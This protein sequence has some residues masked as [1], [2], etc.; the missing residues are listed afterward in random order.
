[1][2]DYQATAACGVLLASSISQSGAE[3]ESRSFE[4][5][6]VP[7]NDPAAWEAA[8]GTSQSSSG[9]SVT[10]DRAL[11]YSPVWQAV[12]LISGDV[13]KLPLNVYR[14]LAAEGREIDRAHPAQRVIRRRANN[15]MHAFRFWRRLMTHALIWNN[16]YAE[17]VRDQQ[18]RPVELLPLLP[19]RTYPVITPSGAV[20]YQNEIA[21]DIRILNSYHVLHIEGIS[22]EGTGDCELVSKARESWGRGLAAVKLESKYY[23]NGGRKG[24]ILELPS[25]MPKKARDRLE[26]D[27]RKNY[28]DPDRAFRT[29]VLRENA[30]FHAAQ[31]D[32]GELEAGAASK[33]HVRDVARWY[34]LPPHK[35]GDDSRVAHNSLEQ[36]N[37]SYLDG[38]LDHWLRTIQ[39]EA[40]IKMLTP[41]Q[42]D[43]HFIEHN[44]GALLRT[45]IRERYEVYRDGI[46][47]GILTPNDALRKENMNPRTD[48]GGDAYLRPLNMA[49]T[50]DAPTATGDDRSDQQAL[51]AA[52]GTLREATDRAWGLL[53]DKVCRQGK[54]MELGRFE[55]WVTD[56]VTMAWFDEALLA[57]AGPL[58]VIAGR[59]A[60]SLVDAISGRLVGDLHW[61]VR[62]RLDDTPA[63]ALA[64]AIEEM[65]SEMAELPTRVLSDLM[66]GR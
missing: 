54:K 57:A 35:L 14:R 7:L 22:V 17:I 37:Q 65:A 8:Y 29:V 51:Q 12:N 59:S 18:G 19:D 13:A 23:A 66:R 5:P 61:E 52:M 36:E 41:R 1:M 60:G 9:V 39:C 26:S 27:F 46:E 20:A 10:P 38:T 58:S 62:Q 28:E 21:G 42:A 49:T 40:E 32:R 11:T 24:G 25:Q 50:G 64:M 31:F 63:E 30:K 56:N 34:N 2:T 55:R 33:E 3:P 43:S 53:L 45:N 48:P 15:E 6:N 4:N 47:L 16:A 44:T